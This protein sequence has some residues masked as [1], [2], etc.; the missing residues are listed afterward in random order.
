MG[1]HPG[2]E[3]AQRRAGVRKPLGSARA[4]AELPPVA[5][6]FLRHQRMLVVGAPGPDGGLRAGLLTGEPGFVRPLGPRLLAVEA[7]LPFDLDGEIGLLAI[8]PWTRRRMRVNGRAR[9]EGDVLL[10]QTDQVISNCPKYLQDRRITGVVAGEPYRTSEHAA[11][12]GRHREWI[13]AA[14]TFFIATHAPGHGADAS[15]RGGMPGFVTA[16]D[17]VVRWLDYP[18]NFMF[19]TLGNLELEPAAALLFV[20]WSNGHTLEVGGRARA[21]WSGAER[22]VTLEVERVVETSGA[23]PLRWGPPEYSPFN[24]R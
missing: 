7:V 12:A 20:D 11:L 9:R 4:R 16:G 3:A 19:L 24:P 23:S 5:Q 10:V 8:E 22:M 13:A 15:H 6:E 18:G 2:E 17:G 21:D 1:A 14:D